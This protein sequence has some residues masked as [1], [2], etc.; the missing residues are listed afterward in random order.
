MKQVLPTGLLLLLSFTA[1]ANDVESMDGEYACKVRNSIGAF[2]RERQDR[3]TLNG[4]FATGEQL[5]GF[6]L[7]VAP[8]HRPPSEAVT[9]NKYLDAAKGNLD[10]HDRDPKP[11]GIGWDYKLLTCT[12]TTVITAKYLNGDTQTYYTVGHPAF[13]KALL[14]SNWLMLFGNGV[15]EMGMSLEGG[16]AVATG[17]CERLRR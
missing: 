15:F 3:Q 10:N 9:C 16:P 6:I 13:S 1:L 4:T 17:K 12:A 2:G 7:Q 11:F 8:V 14:P 5:A